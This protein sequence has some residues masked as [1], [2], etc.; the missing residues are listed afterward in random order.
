M[1][2]HDVWV[3]VCGLTRGDDVD[4]AVG[5][6][7]DA[8]GFALL[9]RSPRRID[10]QL[11]AD[12]AG[13]VGDQA[14]VFVLVDGSPDEAVALARRVGAGGVQPYGAEAVAIARV[15]YAQDLSVLLPI[16][17]GAADPDTTMLPKGTRPLLDTAVLGLDG[18]TGQTFEWE[19][20]RGVPGAVIAGGLNPA[21]VAEAI[22]LSRAW[23]V[24]AS[25]G[26]E[27][28]VGIK[29]HSKVRS[30]VVAAKASSATF[31]DPRWL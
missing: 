25:S 19:R 21:N 9:A 7:A 28:S 14:E 30:F 2:A 8:V 29:D 6:G 12:L 27:A 31:E 18:G 10:P 5:A 16:A 4:V 15:A 1:A 17:V 23:G 13:R 26:L 22:A 24:D 20:A 3:K 11:A